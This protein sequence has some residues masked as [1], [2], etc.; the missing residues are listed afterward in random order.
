MKARAV[1]VVE[2][3]LRAVPVAWRCLRALIAMLSQLKRVLLVVSTQEL[4]RG[5]TCNEDNGY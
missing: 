3:C 2:R 1:A 4:R 5:C